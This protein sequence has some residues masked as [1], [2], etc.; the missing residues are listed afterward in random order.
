[1]VNCF[2]FPWRTDWGRASLY[3]RLMTSSLAPAAGTI[4]LDLERIFPPPCLEA[5]QVHGYLG[6]LPLL[7]LRGG[8]GASSPPKRRPALAGSRYGPDR[9]A[10]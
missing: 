5:R 7:E 4:A 2:S 1:M 9:S 6:R 10:V 3:R 8:P